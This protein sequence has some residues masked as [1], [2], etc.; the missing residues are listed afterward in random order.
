M[1]LLRRRW[2]EDAGSKL[3]SARVEPSWLPAAN[4]K[5][6]TWTCS[7]APKAHCSDLPSAM[8]GKSFDI[9]R[10]THQALQPFGHTGQ[11]CIDPNPSNAGNGS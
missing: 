2:D 9:D 11:I 7:I 8:R 10:T 1:G 6:S 4:G 3:L 5:W